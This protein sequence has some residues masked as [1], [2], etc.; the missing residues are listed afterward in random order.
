ML[1]NSILSLKFETLHLPIKI[2]LTRAFVVEK[3]YFPVLERTSGLIYIFSLNQFKEK[4]N[5]SKNISSNCP[6]ITKILGRKQTESRVL[7]P[8]GNFLEFPLKAE[9]HTYF[10]CRESTIM[11]D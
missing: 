9:R 2:P 8:F 3:L 10:Y 4:S 6:A 1:T 5:I 7:K 11:C